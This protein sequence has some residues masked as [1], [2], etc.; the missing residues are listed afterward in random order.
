M[1]N[2]QEMD[3]KSYQIMKEK[4]DE[5]KIMAHDFD[6]YCNSI[7]GLLNK[8]QGEALRMTQTIKSKN[9]EFLLVEYTNNTALNILLSQKMKECNDENIDFQLYVK[10]IDLSFIAEID[11]VSIFANLI[12]NA[13]E[14]CQIS[15]NKKIF[16]SINI[17]NDSYIVIRIDNSADKEPTV[18]NNRLSTLKH[19]KENHGIGFLSIQKSLEK[20]NGSLR[21]SYNKDSRIFTTT[22]MINIS[23]NSIKN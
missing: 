16:L 22:I 20:Y 14:S 8:E 1:A 23:Q 17:M 21:W 2:K 18:I 11:V 6:K 4:Y 13:I 7:E 5:L 19:D 10:D 9:K 12:D 3:S 15:E